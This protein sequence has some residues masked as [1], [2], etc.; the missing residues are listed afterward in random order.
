M[1]LQGGE[2]LFSN[3]TTYLYFHEIRTY[4]KIDKD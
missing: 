4:L 2:S 3:E 1:M